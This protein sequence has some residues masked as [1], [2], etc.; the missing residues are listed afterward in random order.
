MSEISRW[1]MNSYCFEL[2]CV[3]L[4]ML[5]RYKAHIFSS[6]IIPYISKHFVVHHGIIILIFAT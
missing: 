4:N 2:V 3:I 5:N 1:R 6:Q